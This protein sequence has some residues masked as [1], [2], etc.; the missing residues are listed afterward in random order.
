MKLVYIMS[1]GYFFHSNLLDCTWKLA[2]DNR[3]KLLLGLQ[4]MKLA[5]VW[6]LNLSFLNC[7]I[8]T[9][10]TGSFWFLSRWV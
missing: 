7:T 3:Q 2:A 9:T 4:S 8:L 10:M 5:N 1:R 6:S